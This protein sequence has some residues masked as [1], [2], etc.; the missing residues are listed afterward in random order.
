MSLRRLLSRSHT[1]R[2]TGFLGR[3]DFTCRALTS[4]SSLRAQRSTRGA[5]TDKILAEAPGDDCCRGMKHFGESTGSI[6][7]IGGVDTYVSSPPGGNGKA[8]LLFYADVWGPFYDNSK[9]LQDHFAGQGLCFHYDRRKLAIELTNSRIPC[10]RT[11]LFLGRSR[12][13]S[14]RGTGI[15]STC[16][17][18]QKS[19]SSA[20]TRT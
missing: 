14:S 7:K 2:L 8:V 19:C 4:S 20:G 13:P 11:G 6:E 16:L 15:R 3:T 10:R 5:M 17:E 9:L 12:L 1:A 18:Q